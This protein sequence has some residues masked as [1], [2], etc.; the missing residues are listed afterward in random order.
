MMAWDSLSGVEQEFVGMRSALAFSI[1]L[2][3]SSPGA[4]N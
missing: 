4:W 2:R 3:L 1:A